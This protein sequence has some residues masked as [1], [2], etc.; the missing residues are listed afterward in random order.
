[1][2]DSTTQKASW[3]DI[4]RGSDKPP[5]DDSDEASSGLA[6]ENYPK[7]GLPIDSN[8]PSNTANTKTGSPDP[9][10]KGG[11]MQGFTKKQ[12]AALMKALAN[13]EVVKALDTIE[14]AGAFKSLEGDVHEEEHEHEEHPEGCDCT[15]CMPSAGDKMYRSVQALRKQVSDLTKM[16]TDLQKPKADLQKAGFVAVGE[17]QKPPMASMEKQPGY[18]NRQAQLQKSMETFENDGTVPDF[19]SLSQIRLQG[20]LR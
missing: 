19:A 20:V 7:A 16:V 13:P 9:H 14:A 5:S 4:A 17:T 12:Q 15:K 2:S 3:K 18:D 8:T 6:I 11:V 10:A 1:M